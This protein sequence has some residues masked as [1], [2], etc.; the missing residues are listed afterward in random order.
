MK[1]FKLIALA[2]LLVSAM[3]G[4]SA[5]NLDLWGTS[6]S[7]YVRK[8]VNTMEY[9]KLKYTQHEILPQSLL[10]ATNQEIPVTFKK[11]SPL[12]KIPALTT[13]KGSISDSAVI[14]AYLEK[15]YPG[16]QIYPSNNQDYA[17]A[18]WLE[19]YADTVLSEVIH[20]IFIERVVVPLVLNQNTNNEIVANLEMNELPKIFSYL[21]NWIKEKNTPYL[22]GKSIS[23]A[24]F[25]VANH[26]VSLEPAQINWQTGEY[27]Y[28]EQ[29]YKTM[30]N[31][32]IFNKSIPDI[33]KTKK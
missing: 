8:V 13:S 6:V 24:D 29:Y 7:P 11:A 17:D 31:N 30:M 4:Y 5:D 9:K 15:K 25:A 2:T 1:K 27:P 22:T 21:N 10:E 3:S 16:N 32:K 33:L 12:G 28:L 20:K 26:L 18:L 14:V 23:I 19:K